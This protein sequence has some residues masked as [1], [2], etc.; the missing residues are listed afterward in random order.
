[1][2][3]IALPSRLETYS[4]IG[5]VWRSSFWRSPPWCSEEFDE[6][7]LA[8]CVNYLKHSNSPHFPSIDAADVAMPTLR[9]R[10]KRRVMALALIAAPTADRCG[11]SAS[12]GSNA[13]H[14][15]ASNGTL[16]SNSASPLMDRWQYSI[17]MRILRI[18]MMPMMPMMLMMLMKKGTRVL[19]ASFFLTH[20]YLWH[21]AGLIKIEP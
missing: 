14:L 13:P 7:A 15:V 10:T 1:M 20:A 2:R 4:F 3:R 19:A 8:C 16:T 6:K 21:P 17:P 11:W 5:T 12:D 18:L 9:G